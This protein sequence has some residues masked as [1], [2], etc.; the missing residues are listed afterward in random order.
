[1]RM[2]EAPYSFVKTFN[3][4]HPLA[5]QINLTF[6]EGKSN[7]EIEKLLSTTEAKKQPLGLMNKPVMLLGNQN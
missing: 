6:S 3:Q 1:M 4:L 5:S 2:F 7:A